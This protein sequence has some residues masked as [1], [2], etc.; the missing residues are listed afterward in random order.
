MNRDEMVKIFQEN[1]NFYYDNKEKI[2]NL[3]KLNDVKE[4]IDLLKETKEVNNIT[5]DELLEKETIK[6]Q[7]ERD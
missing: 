1:S 3:I 7:I 2:L 6:N 4:Y 5:F